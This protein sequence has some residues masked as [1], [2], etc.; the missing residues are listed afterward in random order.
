[1]IRGRISIVLAFFFLALNS[2]Q[3][4][5]AVDRVVVAEFVYGEC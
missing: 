2:F 1:M 4:I 5:F 3:L